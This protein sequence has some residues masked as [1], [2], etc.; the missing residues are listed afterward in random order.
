MSWNSD[1]TTRPVAGRCL[2]IHP[3]IKVV[4]EAT[5]HGSRVFREPSRS[6]DEAI[7][8]SKSIELKVFHSKVIS[9][10]RPKPATLLGGG[11][12]SKLQGYIAL[13]NINI[14]VIDGA[15]TPVQ[16]RNLEVAWKAKVIDRTALI[17]EIFGARARTKEG[18]LQVEL[19]ALN[20]QRSR[21]VRSWT[22]LERQRGGFGFMGGPGESQIETDRRMI[23]NRI[24]KLNRQL[25]EVRRTRGLHRKARK[26]IP[27]PIVALVGYTNAGKSTLFNVLCNA[28]VFSEDQLFATLDPTMR[29]LKLPSGRDIILSDTVGFVSEL[30]HELVEAFRATL[31]EV[32]VADLLLHVRDISHADTEAQ[33]HDVT[34]VLKN[35]GVNQDNNLAVK[36]TI[37]LFEVLNKSDLLSVADNEM[38]TT[39]TTRSSDKM[40]LVS[41]VTREG[42]DKLLEAI[43]HKLSIKRLEIS[44][45]VGWKDGPL[46][47]WLYDNG[48]VLER[49]DNN[50]FVKLKIRLDPEDIARLERKTFSSKV[51]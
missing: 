23:D 4:R 25:K 22:H 41:A 21:L 6:L 51:T 9:I 48:E 7:S 27:Y 40:L 30:P 8:L 31:E 15:L 14:I 26:R 5:T 49:K 35:L 29:S 24:S 3:D 38:K 12:V 39:Q 11:I 42:V 18:K 37:P 47:T 16:Q 2:V 43:D 33:K 19:A 17:L 34:Q 1:E 50:E 13:N 44:I 46:L 28:K 45:N 32:E 36:S 20:Y 10:N